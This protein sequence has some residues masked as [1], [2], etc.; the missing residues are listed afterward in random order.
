MGQHRVAVTPWEVEAARRQE[1]VKADF[2]DSARARRGRL[3]I[4]AGAT[5]GIVDRLTSRIATGA[6][7]MTEPAGDEV[8]S[9]DPCRSPAGALKPGC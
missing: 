3:G 2:R 4:R 5:L 6:H 8:A 9:A 7:R 1:L